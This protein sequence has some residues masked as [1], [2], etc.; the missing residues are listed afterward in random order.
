M[1]LS[2][3]AFSDDAVTASRVQ[4]PPEPLD[5]EPEPEPP[6]PPE[7]PDVTARAIA[8]SAT[9]ATIATISGARLRDVPGIALLSPYDGLVRS[10]S[11]KGHGQV[12]S[13]PPSARPRPNRAGR[14]RA[15]SPHGRHQPASTA[16]RHG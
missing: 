4:F 16:R 9:P 7:P 5:P 8:I 15:P 11:A 13:P 12:V 14:P 2:S 10:L 6:E 3:A 1:P